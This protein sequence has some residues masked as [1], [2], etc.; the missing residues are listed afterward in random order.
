[1]KKHAMM[2]GEEE[3]WR[4]RDGMGGVKSKLWVARVEEARLVQATEHDASQQLI[5]VA[6]LDC[7]SS[8]ITWA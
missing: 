4:E 1:M 7:P 2:D 8:S 6:G 3:G 5:G